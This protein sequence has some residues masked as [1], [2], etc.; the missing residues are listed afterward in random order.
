MKG[1]WV[2]AMHGGKSPQARAKAQ[3]AIERADR[4]LR[5]I[6]IRVRKILMKDMDMWNQKKR[7]WESKDQ[8][9]SIERE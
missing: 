7:E 6:S 5:G 3:E 9:R 4:E 8:M 2:C 1:Q